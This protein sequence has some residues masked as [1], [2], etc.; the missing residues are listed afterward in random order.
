MRGI[1][2]PIRPSDLPPG[3]TKPSCLHPD[4]PIPYTDPI[5]PEKPCCPRI[6]ARTMNPEHPNFN[7]RPHVRKHSQHLLS[8]L[9]ALLLG[10]VATTQA[11]PP[12]LTAGGVPDSTYNINLGPTGMEGWVYVEGGKGTTD[13]RQIKVNK[14]DAGSPADGILAVNDVILGASGTGA[15]PS[16]FS[17]DARFSLAQAINQAEGRNPATL[18]LIRWRAGVTTTVTITLEY[19]G[20]SYTVTAPFN[21]PKSAAIL[22]KGLNYIMNNVPGAGYGGFGTNV[23]MAANDPSNPA[24]A[25]R[26]ARAQTEARALNLTQAQIDFRMSGGV[27]RTFYA[28]WSRGPQLITQAEYYLQTGDSTVLPSIRARAIE[29]ANGQ[30]MFGTMGHNFALRK[31][32]GGNNGPYG[33]GYGPVNNAGLPCF[34][35]LVL[36]NKCGLTDAPI[37]AGIDRSAKFFQYYADLGGVPYGENKENVNFMCNNGKS[38][39]AAIALGLLNGYES[40]VKYFAKQSVFGANERD[41]G[42]TG[43]YFNHLW[44]PLGAN[45]GGQDALV[46]YF[47][48]CSAHYDL[49]RR[50]NGD[51]VYHGQSIA[52]YGTDH[53]ASWTMLLTYAAPLAKLHIT[54]KSANPALALN[55]TDM[56]DINLALSYNPA[57][58]TTA[59][60]VEDLTHPLP[61]VHWRASTEIKTNRAADHASI[62]PTLTNMAQNGATFAAQHGALEALKSI[63]N[64]STAPVLAGLLMSPNSKVRYQAADAL[65]SLSLAAKTAHLA[66]IVNSLITYD[67]PILPL[68]PNDPMHGEKA[69]FGSLLFGANG[70]WGSGRVATANRAQLYPAFRIIAS[71]PMGGARNQA[72]AVAPSLTKTD[73]ENLAEVLVNVGLEPPPAENREN[74]SRNDAISVLQAKDIA[75]GVPL[76]VISFLEA[77]NDHTVPL[78]ILR[79]YAAS[80]LTV[81]PDPKVPELC[82]S[83]VKS[84]PT[85]APDAQAI[86]DA[87]EADQ[88]PD[89]LPKK[90]TTFKRIDWIVADKPL[91]NLPAKSTVL[92]VQSTDLANGTPLYTWRKVHGAGNVTFT[93]NGT[94]AAKNTTVVFDG[95]PG[96]YLFEVKVSDSRGLTEVTKTVQVT[97]RDS[98]GSLPPNAP[99]TASNQSLAA[100]QGTPTQL[101]L[102]A[103]DPEGYALNYT[104]TTEPEHGSLSGTAPNLVY[105]PAADYTGPDRITYKVQDSNG[106]VASAMVD[107]TVNTAAPVGLALYEPFDTL[108]VGN[109][110]GTAGSSSIG[111]S[112]SWSTGVQIT[113]EATSL[114]YGTLPVTGNKV[115]SVSTNSPGGSRRI[116]TSA[117]AGRGLLEDG[118]TV[119]MSLL[120]RG[121]AY[122]ESG[123]IS[124]ALANNGFTYDPNIPND[125][126]QPGSGLGMTVAE[127]AVYAAQYYAAAV[128]TP[129]LGNNDSAVAG[130]VNYHTPRLLVAKITWGAASDKIEVFMPWEDMLLPAPTSVLTANVNQS[131]FDTLTFSRGH[132]VF[133]DEIRVGATYQ[134][135]IQG[136]VAMTD[137]N[138]APTPDPMSFAVAPAPSGPSSITMTASTA[139]DSLEVEYYFD[140]TA[141]AGGHD[142]GWQSSR[143]YTDTGLTP[144]VPYT[145]RVKARDRVPGLNETAFSAAASATIAPLGTVPDVVGFAQAIAEDMVE[146]AGLSLGGITSASGYSPYPAGHVISQ[147]PAAGTAAYGSPVNLVISIGQDPALPT[148]APL[149]IVDNKNGGPV[150]INNPITYTLTFSEDIHAASLNAT[151]F[152]NAGSATVTIGTITEISPGVVTVVVTPT[153]TGFMRFAV[154]AGASI[155]DAQGQAYNSTNTTIDDTVITINLPSVSVPNVVLLSQSIATS[156]INS[157]NLLVGTVTSVHDAVV[158]AGKVISQSPAGGTFLPGQHSVDLV[159]SLGPVPER[160]H[161][162]I[163]NNSPADN[164]D[165]VAVGA[166]LVAT[167]SEPIALGTGNITVKNLTS[168]SSA[169]IPV[170]DATQVSISNTVLTINPT[171]LLLSESNYAV[172]IGANAI[173]DLAGN[174]F[175]GITDN[176]TWNFRTADITP[177]SPNPMRFAVQPT[178]VGETSITM[179]A[180]SATDSNGVQY[181]FECTAGGG[182]SSGWQ[183]SPTYTNTGLAFETQYSYRVRARDKSAAQTVTTWSAIFSATTPVPD[184]T[185]PTPNPMSFAVLPRVL[186]DTSITMTAATATDPSG[187]QYFFECTAGGGSNSVW[188]DSPTYTAT[189]LTA[190]TQYSY[191]VRAR[192][193]S[194]AQNPTA[195]SAAASATTWATSRNLFSAGGITWNT[196]TANW[197]TVTAGP[198]NTATWGNGDNANFEG[199]VGT[200]TLGEAI[201]IKNLNFTHATGTYTI[202]GSALNF[203]GG[204]ITASAQTTTSAV[205]A[206]ISSNITGAPAINVTPMDGDE[207]VTLN[208]VSGGSMSIGTVSGSAGSGSE[209]LNLQGGIGSS[210]TIAAAN[211]VKLIQTAGSWTLGTGFGYGHSITGGTL[212][213]NGNFNATHRSVI[214]S[215]TGVLNYNAANAVSVTAATSAS[216]TDNGLRLQTGATLNQTS[217]AAITT[218]T[219]N[220]SMTWEGNWTFTG[221]GG[222]LSNLNLGTGNVFLKAANPLVTVTN[223][224][225]TLTIGGVI[226]ND[227]TPGRGVIKAGSGTLELRGANTYTG[228]TTVSAGTLVINGNQSGATGNVSVAA[229]ATL[230]GT[231]TLGGNTT[232]AANGRLEFNLSTSA[233]SHD[234]LELAAGRTLTFS[235]ASVL[236]INS[237]NGA[238][239]GTYT[240][241]TAP[242][243]I[244]GAIP[245]T[246]NLPADWVATL[247]IVGNDLV[248]DVTSVDSTAP[249][250]VG[251]VDDKGG[252]TI[253]GNTIVNYTVTFSE[254]I[255]AASVSAADFGNAGTSAV[256][257]GAITETSPGVFA[258]AVTPTSAGTLQLRVNA[259]ATINDIAGIELNTTSAIPDNTTINVNPPNVPPVWSG[260]PVTEMAATEE[261]AYT[262][263]VA[264]NATD[265]NGNTLAF[266][267]LS[268]PAWLSVSINGTL[269]GTPSNSDVG[270]NTF[271]VSVSDSLTPEVPVTL[272]ITVTNTN[273]APVFAVNPISRPNAAQNL[274]Y[275]GTLAA[276]ASDMDAGAT[277]TYAKVSGPAW[278]S[279]AANGAFSGTPTSS[280]LGLNTFTVSVSDGIAPAVTATLNLTVVVSRTLFS[281]GSIAWNTT[282][283]NWGTVT[284]GPYNTAAWSGGDS[285]ILEGTAGTLTLGEAIL[286]RNLN[287]TNTAGLYTV[288]GSTLNFT[289]GTITAPNPSGTGSLGARIDSNITGVPAIN[290]SSVG[291]DESFTL[292]P[293][294]NGSMSI[295]AVTGNSGSGSSRLTLEGGAGSSGTIASSSG[296]KV[297]VTAGSWTLSGASNGRDHSVSGGTLTLNANLTATARGVILSGTGVL[298]YNVANAVSATAATNA[299]TDNGFRI[300]GG[301]LDQTSGAPINTNPGTTHIDLGGNL[302]FLGSNGANSNL[303]LG[304]GPV[305]LKDGNR[306]IT[307]TNSAATL[308]IGGVIQN[309]DTPGRGLAKAGAGTLELRGAS[310]YTGA[311]T[312]NA[313]T[314]KLGANQV[315]PN[316][317]NVTIGTAT[318][319]ADTRTDSM[320]TLDVNGDAVIN[321]GNGAALSFADSKAVAWVGTLNIT[322]TLGATSLRFGDSADDLTSGPGGQLSR[323]TVNGGG[324]GTYVLDPNGYLVQSGVP[325]AYVNWSSINSPGSD[326]DDD[327]DSDGLPNAIEFVLGG[328]KDTKDL[329]RLPAVATSGGNMT[330]TFIR[331][332]DS[333]DASVNVTLE[334]GTGLGIWPDV[335]TVGADTAGSSAGVAVSDNGDGT[336]TVTLT[337][338]RA[339]DT[340][341]FA[342]LKVVIME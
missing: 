139:H 176:I 27:D 83:L 116:S 4:P 2:G 286:I 92:R 309:D 20:G 39:L 153:S 316:A 210:G 122:P 8:C 89:K 235:G 117:L 262:S 96:V 141:G 14:V 158:P 305:W 125:G 178:V 222:A 25:A 242:G 129:L 85:Y 218:S 173:K 151:D 203:T 11:T 301:T 34:I 331:D 80:S 184:T 244:T 124:I 219:T 216:G 77:F 297:I 209:K 127:G 335:F 282:A 53:R 32:D 211:G 40:Q 111:F 252:N 238:S 94:G 50:W 132:N 269:S 313:G 303:H 253:D 65:N 3:N 44:T 156:S 49:A 98:G 75:E 283:T 168:G 63:A 66:T 245:A 274:S 194:N 199:S 225:T 267:K 9:G 327:F 148:L 5:C 110:T 311:T 317:S 82:Q 333:V 102:N 324:L 71:A 101:I 36:A 28:P 35:G 308:I 90:L 159:I 18:G 319:D 300:T 64:D 257:F 256:T 24:N 250:L 138:A 60:L 284:A 334:V 135:V 190:N 74:N 341:K 320:G 103:S 264:D 275:T 323:I 321:L 57:S 6:T 16:P 223:S 22:E 187:V 47:N 296:P 99:P 136:T 196:T 291:P 70:V 337:V 31:P 46:R 232:I 131:L 192:D 163:A 54:G 234:K 59:Q 172:Q 200:V 152:V 326:P 185:A 340:R 15:T 73:V 169:T 278:L 145:Y 179:T 206:I 260:N 165:N 189:G 175:A 114:G 88:L 193:K 143:V 149:H 221:S 332:R 285:A 270:L 290:M 329:G 155:L 280:D 330:F 45:M 84:E 13:A 161:P 191:R 215:G 109:L 263:S 154:A 271:T 67:R 182:S 312:V 38:G 58:R 202:T 87:I 61:Q 277:L 201:S 214:L 241:L 314:L 188:Q 167:F 258:V 30:S 140:C 33:I 322:G 293:A 128:G 240:L 130:S 328:D 226:A 137:D 273:D 247:A 304:S 177:P 183:D 249:T 93:P 298:N 91:L 160:I 56:A 279:I 254:D 315:I 21:C 121:T 228:A 72:F 268:G 272:N 100:D 104:I 37:L 41:T 147:S 213:L 338:P 107:I 265:A 97:L 52:S 289:A 17:W 86:L 306:Q 1:L 181:F 150:V 287:F 281:S 164:A 288:T 295:G 299:S 166:N 126:T 42:H 261:T 81:Q 118:A 162:L 207:Q 157:A 134:S 310:T 115:K 233:D 197:G 224:A 208:P 106:Q 198:Y 29:I 236:T 48:R 195:W 302:T 231:G 113:T 26:Q 229:G 292:R 259:G 78:G 112:G 336:D 180:T 62:L 144:G 68:D 255:N 146:A 220:P 251:I 10:L 119:W 204:T 19:L 217:G 142:S 325:S 55:A 205:A 76:S 243:G 123:T 186:S 95:A 276:T 266:A 12:D 230:G 7:L 212:T 248:L 237:S 246:V 307:V 239:P 133:L 174:N 23:L 339:I 43:P 227:A 120:L 318:L 69:S 171:A 105:T 51:F 170:T 108:S 342:R 294:A 79:N